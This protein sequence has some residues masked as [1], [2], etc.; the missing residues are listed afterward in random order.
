VPAVVELILACSIAVWFFLELRQAFKDRH[1]ARRADRGSLIVI[2]VS[3][4]AGFVAAIGVAK[5]APAAAMHPADVAA[6]VG[7]CLLWC[8][9][10]LRAWCFRALGRY[11]TIT[12]QTS[13]D[14]PIITAGPYRVLRHPAYAGLLLALIGVAILTT[15]NW[16]SLVVLI[17]VVLVGLVYRIQVEERALL[18]DLGDTYRSFAATHKRLVPGIW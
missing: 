7:L 14:Q 10:A 13:T 9:V 12:V 8:G 3:A 4:A 18:H 1:Q 15:P 11:F 6:W 16:L 2:R 17:P 5:A